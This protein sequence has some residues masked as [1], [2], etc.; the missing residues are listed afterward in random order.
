MNIEPQNLSAEQAQKIPDEVLWTLEQ[1]H[2]AGY[3]SYIVGGCVR[4][5]LLDREPHDFDITTNAHPEQIIGVFE[6]TDRRVVYENNFG[7]VGIINKDLQKDNVCYE[8]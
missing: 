6:K 2:N 1:L 7:T 5:I 3:E 8:I 4:D